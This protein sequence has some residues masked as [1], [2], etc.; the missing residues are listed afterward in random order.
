[1]DT[2]YVLEGTTPIPVIFSGEISARQSPLGAIAQVYVKRRGEKILI[3]RDDL[4]VVHSASASKQ[5][6]K[7][8]LSTDNDLSGFF[9]YVNLAMVSNMTLDEQTTHVV[10]R[11]RRELIRVLYS[12]GLIHMGKLNAKLQ[13]L[14]LHRLID[15]LD[16]NY[17]CDHKHDI[18]AAKEDTVET[19]L[20]AVFTGQEG[21]MDSLFKLRKLIESLSEKERN[22]ALATFLSAESEDVQARIRL[23]E[24][25]SD[26]R[27][28]YLRKFALAQYLRYAK[29]FLP[30]LVIKPNL[31]LD[32][33]W[34]IEMMFRHARLL[35]IQAK[36]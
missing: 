11:A 27:D 36:K 4:I 7:V 19:K 10:M 20:L 35:E 12:A 8:I 9:F 28:E 18:P 17:L 24:I 3:D 23:A 32:A 33:Y 25:T 31:I 1:M 30:S 26:G 5:Y 29:S 6:A 15:A 16:D 13:T 21:P 14:H 34:E 22:E 2:Y